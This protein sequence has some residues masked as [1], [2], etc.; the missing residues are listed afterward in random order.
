MAH[1]FFNS[2]DWE[3]LEKLEISP[4]YI[5]FLVNEEDTSNIDWRF[6]DHVPSEK[7]ILGRESNETI[8]SETFSNFSKS[9]DKKK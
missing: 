6:T 4:P 5:P 8:S 7:S 3:K 1:P 2:I 9:S